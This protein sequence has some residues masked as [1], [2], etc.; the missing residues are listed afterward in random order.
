MTTL[1]SCPYDPHKVIASRLPY[2]KVRC[3]RNFFGK[4]VKIEDERTRTKFVTFDDSVPA[5]KDYIDEE[6]VNQSSNNKFDDNCFWAVSNFQL[7]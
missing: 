4:G 5:M 3:R 2:H 1:V 6:F 7:N